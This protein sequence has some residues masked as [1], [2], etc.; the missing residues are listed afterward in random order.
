MAFGY[1]I[2]KSVNQKFATIHTPKIQWLGK[3]NVLATLLYDL[4]H[5]QD[6]GK[7]KSS[8]APL[9]K[10][11]KKD[12]EKLLIENFIDSKGKP[13]TIT[14]ISDYL[15]SSKPDKRAKFGSRIEL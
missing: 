2:S 14:T 7:S 1:L 13:L 11:D 5:G 6:K 4:L 15:N 12:L 9:I 10:A 3:T 8:T